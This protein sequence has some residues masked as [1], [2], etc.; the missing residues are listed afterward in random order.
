MSVS[1]GNLEWSKAQYEY[2]PH[3]MGTYGFLGWHNG[4]CHPES[5]PTATFASPTYAANITG[6]TNTAFPVSGISINL[7]GTWSSPIYIYYDDTYTWNGASS[8]AGAPNLPYNCNGGVDNLTTV[9][10]YSYGSSTGS[11]YVIFPS[12]ATNGTIMEPITNITLDAN[13]INPGMC[14]HNPP[15][16]N[17]YLCFGVDK[18]PSGAQ[19]NLG[20]QDV[21]TLN[22]QGGC[23]GVGIEQ[24]FD[25]KQIK[26]YP[27]PFNDQITIQNNS[28]EAITKISIIDV[29]GREV[30]SSVPSQMGNIVI[31]TQSLN[32]G[33][34]FI[35]AYN[36]NNSFTVKLIKE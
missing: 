33:V 20:N 5:L 22:I 13:A 29:L 7:T 4:V 26:V 23:S 16:T 30:L 25:N 35:K 24:V 8:N 36:T 14:T 28:Q 1:Q 2:Y 10:Y 31:Y 17:V 19:Y 6:S 34:F 12:N 9:G 11:D 21:T 15:L 27:N 3:P 18:D 32:N